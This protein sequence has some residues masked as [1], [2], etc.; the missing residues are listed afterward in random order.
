VNW[1]LLDEDRFVNGCS[2]YYSAAQGRLC[3][4]HLDVEE[5]CVW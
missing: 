2:A 4:M 1:V 3:T 5:I